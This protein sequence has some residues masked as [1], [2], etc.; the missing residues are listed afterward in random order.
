MTDQT[1]PPAQQP[2]PAAQHAAAQAAAAQHAHAQQ[3]AA[4][5][6][7]TQQHA[8]Y[9]GQHPQQYGQQ[10]YPA[11][12]AGPTLFDNLGV[13]VVT[14]SLAAS[15]LLVLFISQLL[16]RAGK[17]GSDFSFDVSPLSATIAVLVLT[18][19]VLFT[20][21]A[22]LALRAIL[23]GVGVLV[24]GNIFAG[25]IAD[26]N[27]AATYIIAAVLYVAGIGLLTAAGL[28]PKPT[29]APKPAPVATQAQPQQT[30]QQPQQ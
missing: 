7:A 5:A 11:A 22:T 13:S 20:D 23:L 17:D 12:P 14:F 8:A 25:L 2:D 24:V 1:P 30:W 9:T 29:D 6:H 26:S 3:Q 10:A 4:H 18:A 21:K 15:A 28:L 19:L 27:A 16:G